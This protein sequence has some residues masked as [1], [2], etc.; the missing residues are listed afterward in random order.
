MSYRT[1]KRLYTITAILLMGLI[2]TIQ[3][4]F[5]REKSLPKNIILFIGDGMGVA[6]I[7]AGKTVN[8]TLNLEQFKTVGLLM[9]H[10]YD[11]YITDS[12]A[13]GTALATGF[14]TYNGAI[15]VSPKK[16]SLKTVLEYAEESGKSTG[17]VV[18]CSI[19]HAT[20]ACFASHVD[21]RSK[22]NRIAEEIVQTGVDVLFGGGMGYFLPDSLPCSKREDEK[23][24]MTE[25]EKDHTVIRTPAEFKK[26]G[27][28]HRAVGL[29]AIGHLPP[30][31]NREISLAEMTHKAIDILSKNEN[32]FFLMVEGSQIDWGGHDNDS[33]YIIREMIDFDTAVGVGLAFAKKR[34]DTLVL[35]T[36]DHETGGYALENGSVEERSVTEADFTT[37]SHTAA[38]IPLFAYGPRCDLFGGIHDNTF[39][40]KMMIE[41]LNK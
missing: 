14:K 4:G 30:A 1:K 29:F 15:A 13:A 41:L 31:E 10:S 38:M 20:P 23:N 34:K 21:R 17:L 12:A 37:T 25:L 11:K 7:T 27:T 26:L 22:Q 18:T 2:F 6:Q 3:A 28:P 39:V 33:D 8:G 24:L 35:V 36:S 5:I 16:E 9:T 40:G 19:T 32:G